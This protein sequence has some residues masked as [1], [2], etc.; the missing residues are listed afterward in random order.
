[1]KYKLIK[2]YPGSPELGTVVEQGPSSKSYFFRSGNRNTCVLNSHVEDN[3]EYWKKVNDNLWWIVFTNEE[4][5]FKAYTPYPIETCVYQAEDSRN[6]FKTQ[7]EAEE[8]ILY[9]KPYLSLNDIK[10]VLD[11]HQRSAIE[12]LVKS[13]L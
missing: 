10:D 3:P 6:Y 1:M 8:F 11:T 13:K 12:S 2:D 7:E 9:N 5:S 4:A